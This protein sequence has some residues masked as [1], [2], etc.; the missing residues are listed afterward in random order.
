MTMTL[1][2]VGPGGE[3]AAA[4][5][6]FVLFEDGL[7]FLSEPSTR[8]VR[9]LLA[10]PEVAVAIYKDGQ[11]WEEIWGLQARGRVVRVPAPREAEARA[12]YARRFPFVEAAAGTPLAEALARVRW[13]VVQLRWIRLIDN[14]RGFGWKAEWVR[15]QEEWVRVR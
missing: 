8:H 4:P 13:Y 10:R 2:T 12:A 7:L 5:V 14:R 9:N 1:A 3:P 15:Q 6:F 11:A